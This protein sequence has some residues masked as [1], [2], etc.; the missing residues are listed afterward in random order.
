MVLEFMQIT[1]IMYKRSILLPYHLHDSLRADETLRQIQ[2]IIKI[3]EKNG[4]DI[5]LCN[6]RSNFVMKALLLVL[7]LVAAA[8]FALFAQNYASLK[9]L[10]KK[11]NAMDE[12]R[13]L[14]I[15]FLRSKKREDGTKRSKRSI[16]KIEFNKA[17]VKLEKL[18]RR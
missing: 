15:E 13:N 9:T 2:Q 14:D 1:S 18:E 8:Q 10:N 11:L 5:E 6:N 16:N 3:M 7:C 12:E 17:M 4:K